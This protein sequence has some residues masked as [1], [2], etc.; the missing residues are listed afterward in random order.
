MSCACSTC[1]KHVKSNQRKLICTSCKKY[2]HKKCSNFTSKTFKQKINAHKHWYCNPCNEVV[3]LPFNHVCNENEYLLQ[4]YRF[5]FFF[6][7]KLF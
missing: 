2:T 1:H 4:L 5:F 7:M 6:L 3:G